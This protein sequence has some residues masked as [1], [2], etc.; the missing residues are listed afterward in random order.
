MKK[1]LI[2]LA[3]LLSMT[4]MA[5]QK[6]GIVYVKPGGIGAGTSWSD[7]LGDIQTAINTARADK[8]ARKDVWVAAGNY[9]I[10]TAIAMSDS[11]SLY[12]SFAG[13]ETDVDQRTKSISGKPWEF[14]NPT[15]LTGSNCRLIETASNFDMATIVDGF[16]LTNGNGIG[17]TLNNSGGAAVVRN[18]MIMQNCIIQNSTALSGSGGGLNMTGGTVKNC[19]IY[20]NRQTTNANGGGGIYINTASGNETTVENCKIEKNS[21]TIRGGGINV[22][23]V[24]LAYL[25]NLY[26]VNNKSEDGGTLKAGAAIYANSATNTVTNCIIANNSGLTT[27]YIKGNVLN[28]TMV[29]NI[30]GAYLAEASATIEL[31]NNIFWGMFTDI[32]ETT[33]TSL[34]GAANANATVN[35]N[36]T[37]N[38][39]PTD[40]NWKTS[41]N[42]QFSSNVSNGDV[43]EPAPGTVG[44]GPKFYHVTRF[45]GIA[46]AD[47][48]ILSLDSADWRIKYNSPCLDKG[49]T[50]TPVANDF[51]YVARP[52][53]YPVAS[54]LYDM[55]AYEL[56]Y[57]TITVGTGT[58][59]N[60]ALYDATAAQLADGAILGYGEGTVT[61][62]LVQA[63]INYKLSKLY[64][65]KSTDGGVTFNGETVDVTSKVDASGIWHSD[66][67]L[68]SIKL[69]AEWIQSTGLQNL[70]LY[71]NVYAGKNKI[72][73]SGLGLNDNISVYSVTGSLVYNK[74]ADTTQF[75]LPVE[76]GAFLIRIN[77]TAKKVIVN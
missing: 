54:A 76:R 33:A 48:E 75:T 72:V 53:G 52:Q 59:T 28:C 61:D 5:E 17:A 68:S 12:G 4:A 49:K 38:P 50:L 11:I 60:G 62:F 58:N 73:F 47:E 77:N 34:S 14:T 65:I 36:A 43:T 69:V 31:S 55:G 71:Y 46:T 41:G 39:I 2:S 35:N 64:Y 74:R 66:P 32:T 27:F 67:L 70:D 40:K 7:A 42:I 16:I 63:N 44:S 22:Q 51:T 3:V 19:W 15:T 24:G 10:S 45:R 13:T 37:Y 23:G 56:P 6:N 18:N 25:K 30:G 26:I 57:R 8:A 20:N 1:L 29:N 9:T 21:S